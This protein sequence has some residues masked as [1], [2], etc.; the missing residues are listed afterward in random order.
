MSAGLLACFFARRPNV[1]GPENDALP[2]L[3]WKGM[4]TTSRYCGSS[5]SPAH[6]PICLP[7]SFTLPCLDVIS[8]IFKRKSKD[9]FIRKLVRGGQEEDLE[10]GGMKGLLFI[11]H[12]YFIIIFKY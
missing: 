1:F 7:L 6:H 8:K 2:L 11:I 4:A 3:L 5:P 9:E 10:V 12:F